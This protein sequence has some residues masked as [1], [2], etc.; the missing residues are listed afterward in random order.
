M[1]EV[2]A[3]KNG[4][5]EANGDQRMGGAAGTALLCSSSPDID[6][7]YA[8]C[9]GREELC[10]SIDLLVGMSECQCYGIQQNGIPKRTFYDGCGDTVPGSHEDESGP[11]INIP[12]STR[13]PVSLVVKLSVCC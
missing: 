12:G 11:N 10:V 7:I 9:Y 13:A 3:V 1:E 8:Q 2:L 4:R 5:S 6:T